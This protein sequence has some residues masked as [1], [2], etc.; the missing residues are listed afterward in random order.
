MNLEEID[1]TLER[2]RGAAEAIRSNLLEIELDPNRQLLDSAALEGE[3]A[4]RWSEASASL[5]QLW[6]WHALLE[7]LLERAGELR[8]SRPRLAAKRETQLSDM[9][10]GASIALANEHV[11]LQERQLLGGAELRCTADELLQRAEMAFDQ[12]K[13]VLGALNDA[14]G[15]IPERLAAQRTMVEEC[16]VLARELGE[17]EPQQLDRARARVGELSERLA[18][19]PLSVQKQD[20]VACERSLAAIRE[21]L[22]RL[23][24]VR[25]EIDALLADAR[26]LLAE[27]RRVV[28]QASE[29]QAQARVKI[30]AVEL[31]ASMS[32]DD[33]LER[34]LQDVE[35]I[36]HH[37]AWREARAVLEQ[38]TGRV[39]RLLEQA[40][41][42]VRENRAPIERRNELRGLL[43]AYQAKALALGLI[44]DL[45]LSGIFNEA[46][47][48]LYTAP[49]DLVKASELVNRYRQALANTNTSRELAR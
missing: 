4:R 33:A 49:T 27:L 31:P 6:Q 34:Q 41:H 12:A 15:D 23:E 37:G 19:D 11:P 13:T 39:R 21:D 47:E 32:V 40:E 30:T 5:A 28:V 25:A 46:R 8:G 17:G 22:R 45:E 20:V 44:E 7:A 9:L 3:T 16:T 18:K 10:S 36:A 38:W 2:L 42:V 1:R 43:D 48:S 35:K 14:W 29:A 26:G 24:C